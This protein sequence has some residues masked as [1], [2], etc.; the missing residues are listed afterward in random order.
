MKALKRFKQGGGFRLVTTLTRKGLLPDLIKV[1][2]NVPFRRRSYQQQ[3]SI[4][5][6]KVKPLL[7][8][9][10]KNVLDNSEKQTRG[11]KQR[12]GFWMKKRNMYGSVGYK[13]LTKHQI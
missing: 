12:M 5:T 7:M 11:S 10:F 6:E 2:F 4:L 13:E 1:G 9:E 3:Y 8:K